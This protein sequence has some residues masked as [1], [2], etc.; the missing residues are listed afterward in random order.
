M[1]GGGSLG[2]ISVSRNIMPSSKSNQNTQILL[3]GLAAVAAAGVLLYFVRQEPSPAKA[4]TLD[5]DD[6]ADDATVK[7]KGRSLSSHQ[8][9]SPFKASA[10]NKKTSNISGRPW[11]EKALHSKIEELDKK[12]KAFFKNKQVGVVAV[13]NPFHLS[14]E[15]RLSADHTPC[16]AHLTMFFSSFF[17]FIVVLLCLVF[18]SCSGIY[19]GSGLDRRSDRPEWYH[20]PVSEQTDR[21]I[22]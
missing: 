11:D 9:D 15:R 17:L 12:G 21:D 20:I 3:M 7:A 16:M 18:G 13:L 22:D 1:V 2:I 10:A 14:S 19:R 4:K 6:M 5:D 8:K